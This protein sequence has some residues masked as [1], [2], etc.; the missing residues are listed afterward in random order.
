MQYSCRKRDVLLDQ[1][2]AR[3]TKL[4]QARAV[5]NSDTFSSHRPHQDAVEEAWGVSQKLDLGHRRFPQRIRH[6]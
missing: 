3:D 6:G 2:D 5:K 1:L 4:L